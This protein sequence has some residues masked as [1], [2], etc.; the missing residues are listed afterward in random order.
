M[1]HKDHNLKAHSLP[2]GTPT[3]RDKEIDRHGRTITAT[4]P[5]SE[6]EKPFDGASESTIEVRPSTK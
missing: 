3:R 2:M 1:F 4:P 6:M 5:P